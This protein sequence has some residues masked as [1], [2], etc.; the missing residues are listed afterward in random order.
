[1]DYAIFSNDRTVGRA[2]LSGHLIAVVIHGSEDKPIQI[3]DVCG[4][5]REDV[6]A[7]IV[8]AVAAKGFQDLTLVKL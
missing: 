5:R 2:Y 4:R 8:E 6:E 1:M 7:L 3:A